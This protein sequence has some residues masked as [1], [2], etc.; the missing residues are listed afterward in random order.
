MGFFDRLFGRSRAAGAAERQE[1]D[2]R[3]EPPDWPQA[4]SMAIRRAQKSAANC[5][6]SFIGA[7]LSSIQF[8][9]AVELHP[10]S[11]FILK[12]C[13]IRRGKLAQLG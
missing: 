9:F 2:A 4:E 6:F 3:E 8:K 10:I 5:F 7:F 13:C 12:I 11:A 1:A